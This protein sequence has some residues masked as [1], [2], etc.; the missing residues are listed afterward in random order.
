M[1]ITGIP[2]K[3]KPQMRLL[4]VIFDQ[5]LHFGQHCAEMRRNSRPHIA[6]LRKFTGRTWGL[7]ERQ[8]RIVASGYIRGAL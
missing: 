3:A 4:E 6:Q 8:L 1:T 2:V 7:K 5:L